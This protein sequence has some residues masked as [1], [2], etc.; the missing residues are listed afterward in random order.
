M[1]LLNRLNQYQH[2]NGS[3]PPGK[4]NM[5][6][7][8]N[9]PNAVFCSERHLRT[10][11]RQAQQAGWLRWEAQSDAGNVDGS[12]LPT[13]TPESLRTAMMEQA[14]EKGSSSTYWN[15]RGWPSELQAMLQP[16]WAVMA[17]RYADIAYSTIVRDPLQ[18]GFLPGTRGTASRR[19]KF[20]SG[21]TRFDRDS[22][23]PCGIW[24][25]TGEFPPT[26][27]ADFLYSIPRCWHN[28]DAV[29]TAHYERTEGAAYLPALSKLFISVAR[30]SNASSGA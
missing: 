11:L 17:K 27:Y 13:V 14:L 12:G 22:Q 19:A 10:L 21:L 7:L 9:W 30:I 29:D 4:R 24:R 26:V 28:G 20:F 2:I 16:L 15:W 8:A 25:I 1:R 18:P 6:P 5:S 23:Y 3:L